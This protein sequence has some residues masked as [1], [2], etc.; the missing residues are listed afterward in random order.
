MERVR[1]ARVVM[2]EIVVGGVCWILSV[3]FVGAI[4]LDLRQEIT[5]VWP[6]SVFTAP[7]S[8]GRSIT[9]LAG[10]PHAFAWFRESVTRLGLMPWPTPPPSSDP[11][12]N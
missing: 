6:T 11:M 4:A 12:V 5:A 2:R 9:V 3:Q 8:L 10:A 7:G 1:S